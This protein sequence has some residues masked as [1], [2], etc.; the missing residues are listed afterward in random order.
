M[1]LVAQL[2]SCDGFTVES[3]EGCVGWVEETWLDDAGHPAALALR[4]SDGRRALLLADAVQ[5]VD[6]D[7]QEVFLA[8]DAVLHGL[9][10]PHV[11]TLAGD[12]VASWRAAG[13]VE[14]PTAGAPHARPAAPALAAARA[15]TT[16]GG[17]PAV[18]M[19]VLAFVGLALLVGVEIALAFGITYLV[20]GSPPY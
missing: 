2:T 1:A 6:P 18:H 16:A 17:W 9:E 12:P 3:A 14:L 10:P 20:T 11:Q 15:G 8:G 13:T 5:A 4:T 19:I 7:A